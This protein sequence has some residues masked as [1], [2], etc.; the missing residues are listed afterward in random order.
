ERARGALAAREPRERAPP[1]PPPEPQA[2]VAGVLR[3]ACTRGEARRR[4][5]L[6]GFLRKGR[7]RRGRGALGPGARRRLVADR[8][9]AGFRVRRRPPLRRDAAPAAAGRAALTSPVGA[10]SP[11][12]RPSKLWARCRSR[13][14]L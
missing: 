3:A 14:A 7:G 13:P 8:R 2:L 12:P 1:L 9:A 5:P 6:L 10:E 11:T 4:L